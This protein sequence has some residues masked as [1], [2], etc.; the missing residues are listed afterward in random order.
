MFRVIASINVVI[1]GF[2]LYIEFVFVQFPVVVIITVNN[3]FFE[4]SSSACFSYTIT[5]R[6][7]LSF[8][9]VKKCMGGPEVGPDMW[10]VVGP[11]VGPEVGPGVGTEIRTGND[12]ENENGEGLFGALPS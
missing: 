9:S 10:P 2:K 4:N 11:E 5:I 6:V 3:P 12:T 7:K 8:S 1:N